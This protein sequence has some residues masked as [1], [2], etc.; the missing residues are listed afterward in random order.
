MSANPESAAS[1]IVLTQPEIPELAAIGLQVQNLQSIASDLLLQANRAVISSEADFSKGTDLL[2]LTKTNAD[3]LEKLRVAVKRPLDAYIRRIQD[4]FLPVGDIFLRAKTLMN[5]KMLAWRQEQD[6]IIREEQERVRK[7]QEAAALKRAE[8]LEKQG[9]QGAANAVL[10]MAAA[11][12]V[13]PQKT[14]ARRG[15]FGGKASTQERW[16]A[17][18]VNMREFLK[19]VL[20]GTTNFNLDD[21]SVSQLALNKLA[22]AVKVEGARNGVKIVK[23]TGLTLRS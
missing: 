10:E 23:N 11:P 2:T 14:E 13:A 1:P 16:T 17:E 19:S 5:G 12:L 4:T 20:D 21:I 8:E 15:S 7:E 3:E 22:S 6:R 9:N 18:V